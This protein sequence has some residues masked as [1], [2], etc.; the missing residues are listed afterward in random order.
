V[1]R[2]LYSVG[3]QDSHGLH[4]DADL[5]GGD[6]EVQSLQ[7]KYVRGELTGEMSFAFL[8]TDDSWDA[9]LERRTIRSVSIHKGDVSIVPFGASDATSSSFRSLTLDQ[10][11]KRVEEIGRRVVGGAGRITRFGD[12]VPEAPVMRRTVRVPD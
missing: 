5:D 11:R 10:R 7:R 4:V 2:S 9:K 1:F 3:A 8:C 6:P 12:V